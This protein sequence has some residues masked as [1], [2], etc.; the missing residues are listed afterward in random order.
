MLQVGRI[1]RPDLDRAHQKLI[2]GYR[3][4]LARASVP[5][6]IR[7]PRRS[8]LWAYTYTKKNR[9]VLGGQ[10]T[11]GSRARECPKPAHYGAFMMRSRGQRR[12][13][14]SQLGGCKRNAP[15]HGSDLP[16]TARELRCPRR[17]RLGAN[18]E[19]RAP[20]LFKALRYFQRI[21]LERR[22]SSARAVGDWD[23]MGD[24]HYTAPCALRPARW[25]AA[26]SMQLRST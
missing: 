4:G 17:S 3:H 8:G 10:C 9:Q 23:M 24:F 14:G 6:S 5:K 11:G 26:P 25:H 1:V 19:L 20:T 12:R 22:N 7:R 13:G 18:L 16:T 21:R 2:I 15:L